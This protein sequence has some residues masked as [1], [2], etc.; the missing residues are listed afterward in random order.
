VLDTSTDSKTKRKTTI[1]NKGPK[2][3]AAI[4]GAKSEEKA[5]CND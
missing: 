3:E 5:C 2:Q 1:K 4:L